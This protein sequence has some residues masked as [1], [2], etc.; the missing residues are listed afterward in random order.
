MS[1]AELIASKQLKQA[2][3][4]ITSLMVN[5]TRESIHSKKKPFRAK[6]MGT[7]TLPV[8]VHPRVQGLYDQQ[9]DQGYYELYQQK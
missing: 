9:M 4:F 8:A 1:T 5:S 2:V 6:Q 3:I 7:V